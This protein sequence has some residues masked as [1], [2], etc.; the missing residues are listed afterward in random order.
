MPK[1]FFENFAQNSDITPMRR[2]PTHETA[3]R[4]DWLASSG[5]PQIVKNC[6]RGP[7]LLKTSIFFVNSGL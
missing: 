1:S 3:L 5:G 2:P 4:F 6:P 7:T